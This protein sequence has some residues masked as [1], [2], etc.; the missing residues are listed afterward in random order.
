MTTRATEADGAV[1]ETVARS[2]ADVLRLVVA[3]VALLVVLLVR[4]LFGDTLV[5]FASDFLRG[6]AAIPQ[7]I[8]DSLA[9]GI[10]IIAFVVLIGGLVFTIVRSG[11]RMLLTVAVAVG[12]AALLVVLLDDLGNVADGALVT[13]LDKGLGPATDPRFPSAV[14]IGM[15]AAALTAAAPWLRGGWR[16]WG[17][18]AVVGLSVTRFV[19]SPLSFDSLLAALIGWTAGAAGLVALGGPLKRPSAAAISRGLAAN[20]LPLERIEAASVDARVDALLRRRN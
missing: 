14:G 3:V 2:P 15:L 5:G 18:L 12:L 19:T 10:R 20:G 1:D 7:W 11:W 9:V 6:F 4:W 8:L 17:W 16:R 13:Q